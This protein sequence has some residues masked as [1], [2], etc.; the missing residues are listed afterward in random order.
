LSKARLATSFWL[1]R[2]SL[3]ESFGKELKLRGRKDRV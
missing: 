2:L 1:I 3:K